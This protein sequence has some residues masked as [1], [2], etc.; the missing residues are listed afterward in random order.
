MVCTSRFDGL[1][2]DGQ[3]IITGWSGHRSLVVSTPFLDG[4]DI[5]SAH[6]SFMVSTLFFDGQHIFRDDQQIVT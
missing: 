2:R 4:Q 3:H 6:H 5:V 1:P